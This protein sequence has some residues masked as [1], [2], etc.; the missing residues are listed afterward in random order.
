M[1]GFEGIN[2]HVDSYLFYIIQLNCYM[3]NLHGLILDYT[4]LEDGS[5]AISLFCLNILYSLDNCLLFLAE[6][7][8]EAQQYF[9]I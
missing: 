8:G 1:W 4:V 9:L 3:V 7:L 5:R 6:N 2:L